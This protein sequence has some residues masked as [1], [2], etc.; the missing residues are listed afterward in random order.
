M[1]AEVARMSRSL[2][3]RIPT[4]VDTQVSL[5][6]CYQR[7]LV[8]CRGASWSEQDLALRV[9]YVNAFIEG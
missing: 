9:N 5:T 6:K 1:N 4:E 8:P 3:Q 2:N 7:M